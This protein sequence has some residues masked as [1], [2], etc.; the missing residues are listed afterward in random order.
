MSKAILVDSVT[1][2]T[3]NTDL[4]LAGNG[5]GVVNLDAGAKLNGV[6][7]GDSATGTIGTDVLAPNGDGS[8]LTG[9]SGGA[10]QNVST[11]TFT[12]SLIEFVNLTSTTK[13]V[14]SNLVGPPWGSNMFW[15]ASTDNGATWLGDYSVQGYYQHNSST[16]S[17][18]SNGASTQIAVAAGPFTSSV[19][20][21]SMTCEFIIFDPQ[22][23][24]TYTQGN[25]SAYGSNDGGT[26]SFLRSSSQCDWST[27]VTTAVNAVRLRPTLSGTYHR[28]D[29]G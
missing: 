18:I 21:D 20:A 12:S 1:A 24:T 29:K 19:A 25:Y 11:G 23:T 3:A 22:N 7:L 2:V 8:G 6:A 15:E 27:K 10:W 9:I 26:S 13:I 5:T 17:G 14:L 16:L 4:T 28:M